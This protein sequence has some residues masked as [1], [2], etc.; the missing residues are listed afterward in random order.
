M[1]T[2]LT[3]VA[4]LCLITVLATTSGVAAPDEHTGSDSTK[5]EIGK[6]APEFTLK[7]AKGKAHKL[8]DYKD[9]IVVLQW[10]NPDCPVC[11]RV[12]K[13][14]VL[15]E[16]IKKLKDLDKDYVHLAINS[17]HYMKPGDGAEYFKSH[18][19]DAPVLIDSDGTVG[20]LYDAKTTPHLF[21]IDRKGVLRYSGAL[22]DDPR[23]RNDRDGKETTNYVVN[24]VSQLVAEEEVSPSKTKSYGCSVKYRKNKRK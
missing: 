7:D 17:T 10:I 11:R 20:H 24:A 5:A 13:D 1:M 23:G 2:R 8:S 6:P 19:I 14:G 21:V 22:D 3:A 9:K 18:K 4:A 12:T 16:T 15:K